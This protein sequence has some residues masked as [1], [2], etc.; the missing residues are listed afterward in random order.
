MANVAA[1]LFP[2]STMFRQIQTENTGPFFENSLCGKNEPVFFGCII[3][4]VAIQDVGAL[5]TE[6]NSGKRTYFFII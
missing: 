4:I 2:D 6:H 3:G 5:G 1:G